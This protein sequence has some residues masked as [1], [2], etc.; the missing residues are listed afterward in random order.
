MF[1][2]KNNGILKSFSSFTLSAMFKSTF[3][4]IETNFSIVNCLQWHY[5]LQ[6]FSVLPSIINKKVKKC[7]VP[8]DGWIWCSIA[9]I[10]SVFSSKL[11]YFIDLSTFAQNTF[12]VAPSIIN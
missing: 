12:S 8:L 7:A 5:K 6:T 11:N 9:T 3:L 1:Y 2:D 10:N 4:L